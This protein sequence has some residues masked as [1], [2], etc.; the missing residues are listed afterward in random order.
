MTSTLA[1]YFFFD[2]MKD[3]HIEN[4][5]PVVKADPVAGNVALKVLRNANYGIA[6]VQLLWTGNGNPEYAIYADTN[7]FDGVLPDTFIAA[8][9]TTWEAKSAVKCPWV[10]TRRRFV[11][12]TESMIVF[13]SNGLRLR[14]SMASTLMPA[15]LITGSDFST[16]MVTIP[17]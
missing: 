17:Q 6:S 14:T 8:T 12:A 1:G 4:H 15:V 3:V 7:P 16:S 13:W 5:A 9:A 2:G 11:L 10:T